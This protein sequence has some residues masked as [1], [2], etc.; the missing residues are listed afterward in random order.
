MIE[1]YGVFNLH[2]DGFAAHA[3]FLVD[4]DGAIRWKHISRTTYDTPSTV[5]VIERAKAL[6]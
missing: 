6:S 3:V 1:Q 5:D 4:R 2:G